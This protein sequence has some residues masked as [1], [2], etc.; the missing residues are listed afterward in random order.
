MDGMNVLTDT[1]ASE[2]RSK[3]EAALA[4]E[5]ALIKGSGNKALIAAH[6]RLHYLLADLS[7]ALGVTASAAAPGTVQP[8]SGGGDKP[9]QPQ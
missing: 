5:W 3:I 6:G 8:M 1:T 2:W 7:T 9:P 4:V